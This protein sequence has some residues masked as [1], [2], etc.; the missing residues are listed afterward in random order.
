MVGRL[1]GIRGIPSK[2]LARRTGFR[3]GSGCDEYGSLRGRT[4]RRRDEKFPEQPYGFD[5]PWKTPGEEGSSGGMVERVTEGLPNAL[6]QD[7]N[8]DSHK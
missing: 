2:P 1:L 7:L 3:T 4:G 6:Y 5:L 8:T